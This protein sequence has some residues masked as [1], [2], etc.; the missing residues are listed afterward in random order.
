MPVVVQSLASGSSGN[1]ILVR[2]D[3][4][5]VL[6]DAGIGIRRLVAAMAEVE[7]N[8]ADLS[9]ILLTHEHSDHIT[10]AV[11]MARKYNI[12]L[13]STAATLSAIPESDTVPTRVL[14]A[15]EE[16]D[17]DGLLVRP[18]RISHDAV[19]P[20]GYTIYSSGATICSATDTGI[21]TPTIRAE[22]FWADLLILES[23]HDS[24]MLLTGPYPWYLK[25]RIASD[26]GHLSNDVAAGLLLD[27][28]DSGRTTSVWLAH[29]SQTNN[30]PAIAL[31]SAQDT[32]HTCLGA[33]M[34]I[35]VALR[36]TPSATWRQADRPFQLSLFDPRTVRFTDPSHR[37]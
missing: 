34:D 31:A 20:V 9:A 12:P 11:R 32:L 2:D 35:T 17:F 15:G 25:Q 19:D 10:G 6:I 3:S 23:N 1:S 21:I 16:A 33:S 8:P 30:A 36:D 14:D 13:V 29:L 5:A 37:N 24:E 7:F 28:T 22:A 26:R 27:L 4:G 18:F